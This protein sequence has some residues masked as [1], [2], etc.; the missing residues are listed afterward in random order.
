MDALGVKSGEAVADVGCGRG[1]FTFQL[2]RRVGRQ[3][4][5]YAEDLKDDDL[6][7]IRDAAKK[8]SLPQIETIAG[9]EDD[10]KLPAGA[11][12]VVLVVDAYHEMRDYNSMLTH[13]YLALKPGGLF[14]LIDGV[15]EPGQPREEYYSRHRMPQQIERQDAER[16]GFRFLRQEPGFARPEPKKDY[17]FLIFEKPAK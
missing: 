6:A 7:E 10:P 11:L 9:G 1:Y 17:Y 3:G 13:I 12:D 2:A 4:K 8:Q 16:N 15:A 5:V 14:A